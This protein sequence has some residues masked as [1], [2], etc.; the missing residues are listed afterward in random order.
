MAY[1]G[2]AAAR[3]GHCSSVLPVQIME[4]RAA[5]IQALL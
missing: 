1:V 3:R 4:I 2:S 5:Q